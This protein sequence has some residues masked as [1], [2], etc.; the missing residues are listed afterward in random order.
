MGY[1]RSNQIRAII[2]LR[3]VV[4]L[5]RISFLLPTKITQIDRFQKWNLRIQ[6]CTFALKILSVRGPVNGLARV[7]LANKIEK[8][9]TSNMSL[10]S[11]QMTR[12]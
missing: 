5:N 4:N 6:N 1:F 10:V 11:N 8:P 7:A 2:K 3:L 9:K 12:F